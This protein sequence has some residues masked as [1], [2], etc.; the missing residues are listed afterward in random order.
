MFLTNVLRTGD[1]IDLQID[2]TQLP[3][4]SNGGTASGSSYP[5]AVLD[6]ERLRALVPRVRNRLLRY[7]G[8]RQD[9]ED[10]VQSAMETLLKVVDNYE[11]KG[12][13]ESFAEG[14]AVNVA[15]TTVRKITVRTV[16]TVIFRLRMICR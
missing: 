14:V 4:A 13:L 6:D 15:I 7:L 3:K 16:S 12:S 11:G 10:V 8:P 5:A 1:Q 9:L 2:A